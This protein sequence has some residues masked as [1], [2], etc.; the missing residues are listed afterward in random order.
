MAQDTVIALST[1]WGIGRYEHMAQ[2]VEKTRDLGFTHV[3]LNYQVTAEML[4][5]LQVCPSLAVSSVHSPCPGRVLPDGRWTYRLRMTSE[6]DEERLPALEAALAS[7]DTAVAVKAPVVVL[8]VG[9]VP[10]EPG[11]EP[12]LREMYKGGQAGTGEF[13]EVRE[14]LLADR[15]ARKD[16]YIETALKNLRQLTSY[17]SERGVRIGLESRYYFHEIPNLEETR[18]FLDEFKD[19]VGYWHDAGHCENLARLGFAPHRDWLEAF[20]ERMIGTH[21]HDIDIL[22][23]HKAPGKGTLDLDSVARYIPPDAIRVCELSSVNTEEEVLAG[24]A[25]LT[26]AGII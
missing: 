17:A 1:M 10:L 22:A 26:K 25:V 15:N 14:K 4:G 24:L 7:I 21:L 8:H 16:R 12:R 11:L 23:D 19:A 2:F 9:S 20:S 18:L 6:D 5:Q 3:E 13:Q